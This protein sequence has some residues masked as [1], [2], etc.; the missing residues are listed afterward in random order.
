MKV[1]VVVPCYNEEFVIAETNSQLNSVLSSCFED[2]EIVYVNDGSKDGTKALLLAFRDKFPNIKSIHFSRNFGHQPAVS[3]GIKN[4][5]GDYIVIIDADLQDPPSLIPEMVKKA[6]EENANVVYAVRKTR[7]GESWFK[8][9]TA[10]YYYRL[11]NSMS[12]TQLPLDTGDFRLIDRKVADVFNKIEERQKYI[13]GIITWIG[14]KQVPIE[15]DREERFAGE[16]HYPLSKMIQF[17]MR[18]LLY[19]S[20]K[21]L[22]LATNLG[23][24]LVALS[25]LFFIAQFVKWIFYPETFEIGWMS[26][27]GSIIFFGGIQMLSIGVLGAYIGNIFDEIKNRPEYIIDEIN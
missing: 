14:F 6:Q 1:S 13:R 8:K 22:T 23:L 12:E 3:A 24:T 7:L 9:I 26:I 10:K 18:G 19:F 2:Y 15:Y 11:I 17:A 16:T 27:F 5:S 21:P 20:K 4:A 25:V